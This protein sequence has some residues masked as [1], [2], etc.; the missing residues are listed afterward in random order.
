MTLTVLPAED[1]AATGFTHLLNIKAADFTETT[2]NTDQTLTA[3]G[4][5]V[6]GDVIG[7]DY[8]VDIVTAFDTDGAGTPP[9]ADTTISLDIGYTGATTALCT[10]ALMTSGTATAVNTAYVPAESAAADA[11]AGSVSLLATL[12]ITDADGSLAEIDYGEA[13]VYFKLNLRK[14]RRPA[15]A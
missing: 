8:L 5:L 14:D 12:N 11:M 3:L 15:V 1:R 9:S 13:N 4:S 2:D 6:L 7:Y 10:V